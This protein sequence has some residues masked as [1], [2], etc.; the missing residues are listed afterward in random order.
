MLTKQRRRCYAVIDEWWEVRRP[1]DEGVGQKSAAHRTGAEQR[2]A[3]AV[4]SE[5]SQAA[6]ERDGADREGRGGGL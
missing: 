2:E 4:S 5:N 3:L 1:D 6:G